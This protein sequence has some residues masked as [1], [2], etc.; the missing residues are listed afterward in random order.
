[1]NC[2]ECFNRSRAANCLQ[3]VFFSFLV[4]LNGARCGVLHS[5]PVAPFLVPRCCQA[6][7]VV[8]CHLL[9]RSWCLDAARCGRIAAGAPLRRSWCLDAA[10]C[11]VLPVH[12][13]AVPGVP[14]CCQVWSVTR[15]PFAPFLVPRCCQ[16]WSVAR[17]TFCARPG[18]F[19]VPTLLRYT[20][21]SISQI[22]ELF[23]ADPTPGSSL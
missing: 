5:C 16:V 22:L 8:R 14:R 12:L 7:S 3:P 18:A 11:G 23:A 4:R 15:A 13:C 1:M 21:Y 9:R 20:Y 10:R 6:W 17:C 19:L 2:I